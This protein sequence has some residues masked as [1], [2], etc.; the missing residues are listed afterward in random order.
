MWKVTNT[1]ASGIRII[2]QAALS[3][4]ISGLAQLIQDSILIIRQTAER[5]F[6]YYNYAVNEGE[7]SDI[8]QLIML[9][10]IENHQ[11]RLRLFDNRKSCFQTWFNSLVR[12]HI[13]NY[14]HRQRKTLTLGKL[15]PES[16]NYPPTQEDLI[17]LRYRN[18]RLEANRGKLSKRYQQIIRL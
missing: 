16:L 13:S 14:I 10:L 17:I 12:H 11:R 2:M 7:I 4:K 1:Y 5:A 3:I 9:L 6:K 18:Q 15:A 8:C